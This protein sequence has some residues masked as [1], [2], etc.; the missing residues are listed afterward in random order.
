MEIIARSKHIRITARKLRLVADLVRGLSVSQAIVA[1]ENLGKK[2]AK[3]ILETLKQGLGNATGNF[4]LNKEGLYLREIQIG[5]GPTLKRWRA[6]SRGRTHQI[7]KRTSHIRI[8]LE[9][10]KEKK[11][12]LKKSN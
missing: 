9:G 12:V 5:E 1:L 8:V 11:I 3:P 7:K 4:G 2:A 10:E 6:V